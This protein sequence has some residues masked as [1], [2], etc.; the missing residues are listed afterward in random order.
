LS[1]DIEHLT[2]NSFPISIKTRYQLSNSHLENGDV[3]F[4]DPAIWEYYYLLPNA[5]VERK[6]DFQ[7]TFPVIYKSTVNIYFTDN[8]TASNVIADIQHDDRH[9]LTSKLEVATNKNTITKYFEWVDKPG[10]F[11]KSEYKNYRDSIEKSIQQLTQFI[12]FKKVEPVS[13]KR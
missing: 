11:D 9:F 8:Y 6:V 12:T 5:V 4:K 10:S 3:L 1:I 2:D 13:E 7:I